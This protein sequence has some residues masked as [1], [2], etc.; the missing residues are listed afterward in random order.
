MYTCLCLF[1]YE[2]VKT[3]DLWRSEASDLPVEQVTGVRQTWILC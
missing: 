3:R 2:H 1:A